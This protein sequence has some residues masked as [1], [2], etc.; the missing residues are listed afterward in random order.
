MEVLYKMFWLWKILQQDSRGFPSDFF[1]CLRKTRQR[2]SKWLCRQPGNA[3]YGIGLV[4][5][6]IALRCHQTWQA[7]KSTRNGGFTRK[8]KYQRMFH[9]HEYEVGC[10]FPLN[11]SIDHSNHQTK[12]PDFQSTPILVNRFPKML[13]SQKDIGKTYGCNLK[14]L[15]I[16]VLKPLR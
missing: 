10:H 8:I 1:S 7:R 14:L 6:P 16:S 13:V 2:L 5:F 3:S 11:R 12:S 4:D 15:I 9:W